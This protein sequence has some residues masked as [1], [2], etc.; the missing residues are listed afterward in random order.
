M[1]DDAEEWR[2]VAACPAYSVSNRGRVRRDA[3]G[4]RTRA[5]RIV[6]VAPARGYLIVNLCHAGRRLCRTVHSLVAEAF[7]G[8]Y[9]AGME[10]NHRDGDKRN[11]DVRNLEYVTRAD[12]RRHAY[13]TGLQDA[14]GQQNGHAKLT[15]EQVRAIRASSALPWALAAEH[16]VSQG[17][18]ADVLARRTWRH[19]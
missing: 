5:G 17:C 9:P 6:R 13:R 4:P 8:P 2:L 15:A 3:P 14:R 19:L 11:A 12:N 16:G 18:V 10:V 1:T 7:L